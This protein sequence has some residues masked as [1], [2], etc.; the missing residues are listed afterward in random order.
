MKRT[1]GSLEPGDQIVRPFTD[2]TVVVALV[3]PRTQRARRYVTVEF[4]DG[5]DWSHAADYAVEMAAGALTQA[6]ITRG[7]E[8]ERWLGWGY[9]GGRNHLSEVEQIGADTLVLTYANA[10]GWDYEALFVWM[11][12][13]PGRWFADD[14][15]GIHGQHCLAD[16][17]IAEL[18]V[19]R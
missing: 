10:H 9:L 12:S 19:A 16:K 18:Q 4:T 14:P 11:N 7:Y 5:T 13:K 15:N 1:L 6:D 2:Q 17:D 8:D 3:R